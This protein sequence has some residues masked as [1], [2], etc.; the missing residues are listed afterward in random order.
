LTDS[1]PVGVLIIVK[2]KTKR[3]TVTNLRGDMNMRNR[4]KAAILVVGMLILLIS[5]KQLLYETL[6]QGTWEVDEHYSNG[7]EDTQS[8]YLIFGD[9]V[10]TFHP[11]GHFTE[12]YKLGNIV[13]VIN[14]GTW[15]ISTN[16]DQLQLFD[17]A[18][19]RMYNIVSLTKDELRLQRDIGDGTNEE[20][21]LE[22]KAETP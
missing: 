13:P 6:I 3:F 14:P 2:V 5:C 7:V 18:P 8:F 10:I 16:G 17:Q 1:I 11:D 9:Y 21:V 4:K 20:L 12:T 22:P 15:A 19:T